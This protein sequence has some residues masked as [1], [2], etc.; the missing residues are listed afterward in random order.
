MKHP[1]V[2]LIPMV[3][4]YLTLLREHRVPDRTLSAA[5]DVFYERY[6]PVIVRLVRLTTQQDDEVCECVQSVWLCLVTRL[7]KLNY[8]PG[9][10]QFRDWLVPTVNRIVVSLQRSRRLQME[11]LND[12][13]ADR[14]PGREDDP[15]DVY[16]RN[17]RCALVREALRSLPRR[18]SRI[19]ARILHLR[20]IEEL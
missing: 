5:W 16:E 20:M 3:Q 4:A 10:G 1:D 9:R 19:N 2:D 15:V 11:T 12:I 14:L 6:Q 7:H 18:V 13:R 17:Q 8:D